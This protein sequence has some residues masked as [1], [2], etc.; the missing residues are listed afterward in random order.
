MLFSYQCIETGSENSSKVIVKIQDLVQFY[1]SSC[2][3]SQLQFSHTQKWEKQDLPLK[4]DNIYFSTMKFEA[5]YER[6]PMSL[7]P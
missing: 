1:S 6:N 4:L 3:V 5:L 7:F 2:M